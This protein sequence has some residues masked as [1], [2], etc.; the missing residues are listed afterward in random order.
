MRGKSPNSVILCLLW[1]AGLC[2]GLVS[3]GG[4]SGNGAG[5]GPTITLLTPSSQIVGGSGFDLQ[6]HGSGFK[7]SSAIQWNGTSLSTT[8]LPNGNLDTTVPAADIAATGKAIVTVA[9]PGGATS[10]SLSFTIA[11]P[12]PPGVGVVQLISI[13]YDGQPANGNSFSTPSVSS[14]GRFVAFH[15]DAGNLVL[16]TNNGF[17]NIFLRDTCIGISTCTPTTILV[18]VALNGGQE[19]GN[20]RDPSISA[21]GRYVVFDS[22]ATNLIPNDTQVNGQADVFLRD[23]CNGT[24]GGCIPSTTR[25]S[26]TPAASQANGD[27]RFGVISANGRFVAFGS[28]APDLV[29]NDS[30]G[31]AD[32]FVRDTCVGAST[33]CVPNTYFVSLASNGTQGNGA[34]GAPAI[35]GQGRFVLFLSGATNLAPLGTSVFLRDSCS[36]VPSGCS[37]STIAVDVAFDG[38]KANNGEAVIIPAISANGRFATFPS[39]ATNLV[40]NDTNVGGYSEEFLRD[41]CTGVAV[42]CIPKTSKVSVAFDG[43]SANAGSTDVGMD[44][45]G[46]FVV[47]VSLATNLVPGGSFAPNNIFLR[48]TCFG[49]SSGC[50]PNTVLIS[51]T[52]G[53]S[54]SSGV[55]YQPIISADGHFVVFISTATNFLNG[56]NGNRQV[57]LAA[58][59]F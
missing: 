53:G 44:A 23:T 1:V 39:F 13:G 11:A 35:S 18:S 54:E 15:S 56:S 52:I 46:R 38:S 59:S 40:P 29:P 49:I 34:S 28:G 14:N 41:T 45:T 24:L 58:S 6:V 31:Y 21:D 7:S 43:S 2:V 4:G 37:P 26:V 42:G 48:D 47:F 10:N 22:S 17:T 30:N 55:S 8:S 57:F 20:S 33:G 36:G 27:S 5:A 3:C 9:N 12:P 16:G 25:I 19:N 50:T 51:R 32:A